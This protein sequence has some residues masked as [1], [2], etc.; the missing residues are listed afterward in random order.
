MGSVGVVREGGGAVWVGV[1][2]GLE[3]LPNEARQELTYCS[4][5]LPISG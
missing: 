3:V 1:T 4:Q 2:C 5:W